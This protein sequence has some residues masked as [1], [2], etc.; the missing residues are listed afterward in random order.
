[1]SLLDSI[2]PTKKSTVMELVK[3]AGVDVS[4][5]SNMDSDVKGPAENPK[6]NN[7]WSFVQPGKVVVLNYWHQDIEEINKKLQITANHKKNIKK[8]QNEKTSHSRSRRIDLAYGMDEG[9]QTAYFNN[10]PIRIIVLTGKKREIDFPY[11]EVSKVKYRMLDPMTWTIKSYNTKTGDAV[12]IRDDELR[13]VEDES[14]SI[15]E[16]TA[17]I[18][19]Y[20]L[21]LKTQLDKKRINKSV[22]YEKLSKR[23]GR[24]KKAFEY[25]MQNISY[26]LTNMGLPYVKG[27][28]PASH[29]GTKMHMKLQNLI[30]DKPFFIKMLKQPTDNLEDLEARTEHLPSYKGKKP[31][32]GNKKPK[33]TIKTEVKTESIPRDPEVKKWV[34]D[35]A[36]GRCECCNVKAPFN[37]NKGRPYLEVH[38]LKMLAKLGSDTTENAIAICP[39]CHRELHFGKN[40]DVLLAKVYKSVKRLIP[41]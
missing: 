38:H 25:R 1:M 11:E 6:Y 26:V 27:L 34:K 20:V 5:W 28:K 29:V 24:S 19:I 41:E 22:E 10:I 4:D 7:R 40:K 15:K 37:N 35:N 17:S 30:L 9:L 39:N 18:N 13:S 33:I 14:W 36:D 16:L 8:L 12:L 31:P 2:L 32:K 21:I 23:F 3:S